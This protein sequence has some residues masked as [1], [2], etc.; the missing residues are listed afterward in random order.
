MGH[1]EQEQES[2]PGREGALRADIQEQALGDLHLQRTPGLILHARLLGRLGKH[3]EAEQQIRAALE[4]RTRILGPRHPEGAA[5]MDDLADEIESQGRHSTADAIRQETLAI[6][7][8]G[9]GSGHPALGRS[10]SGLARTAVAQG[11]LLGAESMAREGLEVREHAHGRENALVAQ[12]MVQL[13]LILAQRG[14]PQIGEALLRDAREILGRQLKPDHSELAR[15]DRLLEEVRHQ[16][17]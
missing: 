15:I 10:F 13:A 5:T 12:S 14:A 7:K 11:D 4:L 2:G 17:P 6:R 3:L 1:E 8:L 9:M 16:H